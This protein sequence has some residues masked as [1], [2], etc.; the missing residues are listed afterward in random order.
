VSFLVLFKNIV[1]KLVGLCGLTALAAASV[2]QVAPIKV[3]SHQGKHVV[4]DSKTLAKAR[5]RLMLAENKFVANAGQW[6]SRALF[7]ARTSGLDLWLEKRG[8]DF[9][10]YKASKAGPGKKRVGQVI[11]LDFLGG[12]STFNYVG[13]NALGDHI[14]FLNGKLPTKHTASFADVRAVDIY[15]GVDLKAY[16]DKGEPRYD[17]IVK[18]NE[19][20]SRIKMHFSGAT[21]VSV[22]GNNIV[23]GTQVGDRLQ[24]DL[25]AY[26]N[27]NG[28]QKR[29]AANFVS[30]GRN[31]VGIRLGDYNKALPLVIDPLVYGTY[32]GGDGG[33]DE[34]RA[35]V[36]DTD[37]GT[38]MTGYTQSVYFPVMYGPYGYNLLGV[39]NAFLS[40]LQGDAYSQVYAAYIG[41]G[42]SD[43]AQFIKM[44]TNGNIWIAGQTTSS[45]FPGN[46]SPNNQTLIGDSAATGGTFTLSY[47]GELSRPIAWNAPPNG[48]NSVQAALLTIPALASSGVTVVSAGG[49]LPNATYNIS[50]PNSADLPQ[51]LVVTNTSIINGNSLYSAGIDPAIFN[52]TAQYNFFNPVTVNSPQTLEAIGSQANGGTFTLTFYTQPTSTV[53][54]A[55]QTTTALKYNSSGA[56]IQTALQAL[57]G[58]GATAGAT[59][60]VTGGPASGPGATPVKISFNLANGGAAQFPLIVNSSL[61]V[62]D[63]PPFAAYVPSFQIGKKPSIFVM[64]FFRSSA[65]VLDPQPGGIPSQTKI[66]G[67]DSSEEFQNFDLYSPSGSTTVRMLLSGTVYGGGANDYMPD[68]GPFPITPV[69]GAQVGG[70]AVGWLLDE[71][72]TESSPYTTSSEYAMTPGADGGNV[73][74]YISVNTASADFDGSGYAICRGA[75]YDASGNIFVAGTLGFDKNEDTGTFSGPIFTTTA[76]VFQG[77]QLA[78]SMDAFVR[79][80]NTQ[81][82]LQWSALVGGQ[83]DDKAG[84]YD[85]GNTASNLPIGP[86]LQPVPT[87]PAI[88]VD[89]N[90]GVYITGVEASQDFPRTKGAYGQVNSTGNDDTFVTKISNDGSQILYST[91]LNFSDNIGSFYMPAGIA[92]N[93]N[94]AVFLTGNL[95]PIEQFPDDLAVQTMEPVPDQ[96]SNTLYASISPNP[97]ITTPTGTVP[98]YECFERT[99]PAGIPAPPEFGTNQDW[100]IVLNNTGSDLLFDSYLGGA[101]DNRVYA[102]YVDTFGD[103]WAMGWVDSWRSYAV[104]NASGPPT[105]HNDGP[106]RLPVAANPVAD[107]I[108]ESMISSLAFKSYPDD[109]QDG[110]T[111]TSLPYGILSAQYPLRHG[112]ISPQFMPSETSKDGWVIRV[113]IG[114]PSLGNL[115]LAPQ[116]VPGGLGAFSTGTLTLSS[117]APASGVNVDLSITQGTAISFSSTTTQT[118]T[119]INIASGSTT[120]TFKVYSQAVSANTQCLVQANLEGSILTSSVTVVPWLQNLQVSPTNLVG[121]NVVNGTVTIAAAAPTGGIN[122]SLD[123]TPSGVVTLP[124]AGVTIPA[125]QTSANFSITTPGVLAP[126]PIDVTATLLS[127]SVNQTLTLSP[128]TVASL[129]L[130]PST[131]SSG[132]QVQGT[133]T[134][135][136]LAGGVATGTGL[137]IQ[138]SASD[139]AFKFIVPPSTVAVAGPVTV[140]IA[141]QTNS[142][143]FTIQTPISTADPQVTITAAMAAQGNNPAGTASA[144]LFIDS[145]NLSG[146]TLNPTEIAS[147]GTSTGTITI[148]TPAPVGGVIVNIATSNSNVASVPASVTIPQGQTSATFTVTGGF[149]ATS[150]GDQATITVGRTGTPFT[151]TITVDPLPV[152]LVLTPSDLLGGGTATG[153]ITIGAATP[154]GITFTVTTDQPGDIGVPATVT[155]PGGQTSLTFPITSQPVT[156]S[157]TANVFAAWWDGMSTSTT[158]A[159]LTLEPVGIIGLT[160]SPD[161]VYQGGATSFTVT[162][163]GTAPAGG[164]TVMLSQSLNL[165]GLPSQITIPAGQSTFTSIPYYARRVPR[166]LMDTVTATYNGSTTASIIVQQ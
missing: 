133:V 137:N 106:A 144:V 49:S 53:A 70:L 98:E 60:T 152:S 41:G 105:I 22:R 114:L 157:V 77:G 63:S 97:L 143:T 2:A 26:Q 74:Q 130:S 140:T 159:P 129:T 122:I 44:D 79:K 166:S 87:G 80:Y 131:I 149:L 69:N 68:L 92:V 108:W 40:K 75:I 47:G 150:T 20:P 162:L 50:I 120:G 116:T 139:P 56:Q 123:A 32:Y 151:A 59:A 8:L 104:I 126:T 109:A 43:G 154:N 84:G 18:A 12:S 78:Q 17:L 118:T 127:F 30:A 134:L 10:Y 67:I 51:T 163:S 3:P 29:V 33:W 45:N 160:F 1:V 138:I 55:A 103:A 76:G 13:H 90:G 28:K 153:T 19:D 6:D 146:F 62:T 94:G 101:L 136:G 96:P 73:S 141:P 113:R 88:A 27:I 132:G 135:N 124:T 99:L 36:E 4:T 37:G 110:S 42:G 39:Q 155:V 145:F 121:G 93:T 125:G 71:T 156:S 9:D 128:A 11:R 95:H 115:T 31:A 164:A 165:L 24:G 25:V 57:A 5:Q 100:M 89:V 83:D 65:T 147:G 16:F 85:E 52:E 86:A 35:V 91:N 64:P 66:F 102:P 34:V 107:P 81:G 82:G 61:S 21:S 119:T 158:S 58:I 15:P 117:P 14:D 38:F 46:T 54:S 111:D 142:A 72:Y 148:G 23:L 48:A 7:S 161:V 112:P